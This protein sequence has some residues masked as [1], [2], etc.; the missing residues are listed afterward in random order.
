MEEKQ[1]QIFE[2]YELLENAMKFVK[3]IKEKTVFSIGGRG[4]YENPISDVLAF[5]LNPSEEH[6]FNTLFLSSLLKVLKK[7]LENLEANSIELIEREAITRSGNRIDLIIVSENLVII[8]E[9]KIY[10]TLL[11][12]LD[13]YESYAASKYPDKERIFS[14]LSI[15]ELPNTPLNWHNILYQDLIFEIKKQAGPYLFNSSNTKWHFFL[16]DFILNLEELIGENKVNKKMMDFVQKNYSKIHE[17]LEVKEDYIVSLKNMLI[18]LVNKSSTNRI[19]NKIHYWSKTTVAIRFYQPDLW[20]EQ[21]NLVL[22]VQPEGNFKIYYYVCGIEE[23]L[24]EIENNK[25]LIS[26]YQHW[27]ENKGTIL[28]YKSEKSFNLEDAKEAFALAAQHLNQ[29]FS[30]K[31]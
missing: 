31:N 20:G 16:K 11:N 18:P 28:C 9:N 10:H 12:P 24:R 15:N 3:P 26:G 14:I 4:H 17:L 6:Q 19:L 7:D 23:N 8:I 5:F 27:R 1:Q 13:D 2:Y 21:T 22:V 30:Y 25:L 29:Y